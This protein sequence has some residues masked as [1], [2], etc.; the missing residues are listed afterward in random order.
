MAS[1][2]KIDNIGIISSEV[3]EN[4]WKNAEIIYKDGQVV[5][6]VKEVYE[7]KLH[8][9]GL[10]VLLMVSLFLVGNYGYELKVVINEAIQIN[11]FKSELRI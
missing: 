6:A 4:E 1:K 11:S 10:S 3:I 5:R 9:V 2:L 8:S 7:N